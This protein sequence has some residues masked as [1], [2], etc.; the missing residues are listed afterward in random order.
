MTALYTLDQVVAATKP[1][2]DAITADQRAAEMARVLVATGA[3]L[4]SDRDAIA[5]LV[6]ARYVAKEICPVLD[7]AIARARA[8]KAE[9]RHVA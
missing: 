6:R 3:N 4:N 7:R 8:M 5:C 2:Y 9:G 1:Y